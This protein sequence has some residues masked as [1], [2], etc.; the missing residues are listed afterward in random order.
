MQRGSGF[1]VHF[2]YEV[3]VNYL[4]NV[5]STLRLTK[6]EEKKVDFKQ[7]ETDMKRMNFFQIIA[8]SDTWSVFRRYNRFRELHL[9]LKTKYPQISALAFPPKKLFGNRYEKIVIERR[10]LLEVCVIVSC[11]LWKKA[12]S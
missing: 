6:K 1:D 11:K 5:N 12:R 4:Q 7:L 9:D 3:K 2:E 10:R 8:G